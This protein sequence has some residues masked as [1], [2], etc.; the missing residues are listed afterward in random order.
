MRLIDERTRPDRPGWL[1][2]SCAVVD[3][4]G[5]RREL[6]TIT[7]GQDAQVNIIRSAMACSS[8]GPCMGL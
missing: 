5:R 1:G 2:G 3:H 4:G 8:S 6:P 7:I